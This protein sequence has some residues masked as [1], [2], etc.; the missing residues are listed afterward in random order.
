MQYSMIVIDNTPYCFWDWDLKDKN[1]NFIKGFDSTYFEYLGAIHSSVI[2][3]AD[4]D[5]NEKQYASIAIRNAYSHALETFFALIG[6]MLQAPDY[7]P[8]W[9][10]KYKTRELYSLIKKIHRHQ[11][12]R[13]KIKLNEYSWKGISEIVHQFQFEDESKTKEIKDN[14]TS[15]WQRLANDFLNEEFQSEYNSIKHGYRAKPGG[16]RIAIGPQTDI[17]TPA[18]PEKMQSLGGSDYGSSFFIEE[19]PAGDKKNIRLRNKSRNW[20]P[21]NFINALNLI[22]M[23]IDNIKS[24][25]LIVNGND[26]TTVRFSWPQNL[27]HF[28]EHCKESPGVISL[29]FDTIVKATDINIFTKEEI[30]NKYDERYD[31]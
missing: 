25:L 16:F 1:L 20:L 31:D 17:N 2:D 5:N 13:K 26:P 10:N 14:F 12:F 30:L 22:R 23:S 6:A 11:K 24:F 21:K 3:S 15:F 19:Y 18:P 8:G 27:E 9:L 28:D 7:I 4:S 29:G